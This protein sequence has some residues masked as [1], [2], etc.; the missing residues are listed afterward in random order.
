MSNLCMLLIQDRNRFNA[1]FG[2]HLLRLA[3]EHA[4]VTA[5]LYAGQAS[6]M[7]AHV[8]VLFI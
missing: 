7:H 1:I 3:F 8:R 6:C 5:A 4:F 2:G